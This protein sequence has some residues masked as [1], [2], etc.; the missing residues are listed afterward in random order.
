MSHHQLPRLI[1]AVAWMAAL[2][3]PASG[4][5][6]DVIQAFPIFGVL[7]GVE[8]ARLNAVLT[9]LDGELPCPVTLAFI[10]SQGSM[11]GNPS[12]FELRGGVAVR[13]DFVGNPNIRLHERLEIRAQVTSGNPDVFPGCRAGVLASVEVF[14]KGTLATSIILTNPV[15]VEP[16]AGVDFGVLFH[17]IGAQAPMD[18][19]QARVSMTHTDFFDQALG[20]LRISVTRPCVP[21][22][23]YRVTLDAGPYLVR[24]QGLNDQQTVCYESSLPVTLQSGQTK[25]LDIIAEQYPSGAASGCVYPPFR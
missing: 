6:A 22:E 4:A 17:P 5:E 3:I 9:S 16:P 24:V 21:G 1:V 12:D 15:R 13:T 23:R 14:D 11:V 10:D 8:T 20:L 2:L 25:T 18:C 19:Q 7:N